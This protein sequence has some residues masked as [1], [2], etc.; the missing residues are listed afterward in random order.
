M[1][2]STVTVNKCIYCG[3]S[4]NLSDEHT[5]PF[6]LWGDRK[7][8][9]GS[10]DVC[11]KITSGLELHVARELL[12]H[13]R[14]LYGFR[15]RRKQNEPKTFPLHVVGADGAKS[16]LM[17]DPKDH[18]A[19]VTFPL[20]ELPQMLVDRNK[21]SGI[22]VNGTRLLQFG[23]DPKTVK[24][25]YGFNAITHT[26]TFKGNHFPRF[27]A[28][29]AY[30]DAVFQYGVD[31]FDEVYVI[32]DILG[33][34][35]GIGSFVGTDGQTSIPKKPGVYTYQFLQSAERELLARL[36]LFPQSDSP[37]YLVLIGKLKPRVNGTA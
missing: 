8:I 9:R 10:C 26:D 29:W 19:F 25:R 15:S 17:L 21:R 16:T 33:A 4:A 24:N 32:D 12:L 18:P 1:N 30:C 22:A 27:L 34:T 20:Y 11:A 23:V 31:A 7:L 2:E 6:S 3:S 14:V 35:D 5:F 13:V 37:E 36:K 28:K